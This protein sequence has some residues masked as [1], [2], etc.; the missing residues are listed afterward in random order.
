MAKTHGALR[1][2]AGAHQVGRPDAGGVAHV[3]VHDHAKRSRKRGHGAVLAQT[4]AQ[5]PVH[6][7]GAQ[8]LRGGVEHQ[9]KDLGF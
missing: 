2:R 5:R 7:R 6:R 9:L 4:P 8:R 3:V 1:A